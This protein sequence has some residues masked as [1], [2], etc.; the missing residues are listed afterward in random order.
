MSNILT[1]YDNLAK[2]TV[3]TTSGKTPKVYNLTALPESLT[4][5]HLP[6]RLLLSL[7]GMPG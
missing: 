3:T 1:A 6:C 5:A 2:V 7:G 4:A